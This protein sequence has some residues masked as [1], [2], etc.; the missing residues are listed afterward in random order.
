VRKELIDEKG[1]SAACA[2]KIGAY[3]KLNGNHL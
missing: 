2:D 3:A 1:I